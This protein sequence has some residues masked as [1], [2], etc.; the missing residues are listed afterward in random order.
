[1]DRGAGGKENVTGVRPEDAMDPKEAHGRSDT[2][3]G[4]GREKETFLH[5]SGTRFRH[6][7]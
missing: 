1:V 6:G 5:T 2:G 3:D 4:V 7:P